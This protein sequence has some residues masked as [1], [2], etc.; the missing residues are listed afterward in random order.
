M[1]FY[2]N[3]GNFI[4][5]PRMCCRS[6][7]GPANC[8]S[9]FL[10]R[11]KFWF[12]S[13]MVYLST[14]YMVLGVFWS[15]HV[16]PLVASRDFYR[17]PE[18]S[19]LFVFIDWNQVLSFL[20]LSVTAFPV[21][22]LSLLTF[23]YLVEQDKLRNE[24]VSSTCGARRFQLRFKQFACLVFIRPRFLQA[25]S[26]SIDSRSKNLGSIRSPARKPANYS[27]QVQAPMC[28]SNS[29]RLAQKRCSRIR[30]R[31]YKQHDWVWTAPDLTRLAQKR[32]A[33]SRAACDAHH[34]QHDVGSVVCARLASTGVRV[35]F[36][37]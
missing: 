26:A 30:E 20:A 10:A 17:V 7:F 19:S 6:H 28:A 25:I 31:L 27:A 16:N 24:Q 9:S 32:R 2:R 3:F 35:L 37:I 5:S 23:F 1:P 22:F 8:D 29:T 33:S 11:A 34:G 13:T 18:L 15:M 14:Q 36:V 12:N 4:Y 21:R